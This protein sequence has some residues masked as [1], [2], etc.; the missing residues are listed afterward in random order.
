MISFDRKAFAKG[1]D[2]VLTLASLRSLC[3]WHFQR[4]L[5]RLYIRELWGPRCVDYDKHCQTCQRW[6]EHD[7]IFE[8]DNLAG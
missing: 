1:V 6:R 5:S 3:R 7:D 8:R 4:A 2:D